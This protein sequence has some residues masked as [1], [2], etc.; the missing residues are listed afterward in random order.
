[1]TE[2]GRERN[3]VGADEDDQRNSDAGR[4]RRSEIDDRR[5]RRWLNYR[6]WARS[7]KSG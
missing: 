7:A 1:M 3:G 6:I 5:E 2:A 4:L